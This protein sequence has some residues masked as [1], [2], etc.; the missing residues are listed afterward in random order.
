MNQASRKRESA[1]KSLSHL[2]WDLLLHSL[3]GRLRD[4][5]ESSIAVTIRSLDRFKFP[6][7]LAGRR[8]FGVFA[9]CRPA[10]LCVVALKLRVCRRFRPFQMPFDLVLQ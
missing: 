9:D 2:L 6:M 5:Y 10:S 3:F 1:W 4:L 8:L 7:S